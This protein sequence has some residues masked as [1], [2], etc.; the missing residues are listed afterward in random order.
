MYDHDRCNSACVPHAQ[1][2]RLECRS[3]AL[4]VDLGV[5]V[6]HEQI[7]KH[8]DA[9]KALR[10]EA[11]VHVRDLALV[12]LARRPERDDELDEAE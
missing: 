6:E 9:K 1:L 12:I 2:R 10:K 11:Q 7:C 4:F 8:D 5:A 3:L